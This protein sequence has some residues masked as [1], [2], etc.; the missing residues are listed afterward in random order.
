M[1]LKLIRSR[2]IFLLVF[3]FCHSAYSQSVDDFFHSASQLYIFG[4]IPECK[5]TINR[6]LEKYPSNPKLNALKKKL[7]DEDKKN[8][9]KNQDKKDKDDKNKQKQNKN[10][11]Q[12]K[13]KKDQQDQNQQQQKQETKLSKEAA[14]RMLQAIQNDEKNLQDKLEKQKVVAKKAKRGQDW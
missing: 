8:Q 7:K 4:K 9:N 2:F 10:K 12:N 6:A 5:E 3:C 1:L 14:K 13:D 11:D